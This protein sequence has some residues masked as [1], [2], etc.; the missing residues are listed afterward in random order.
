MGK[1]SYAKTEKEKRIE[2]FFLFSSLFYIISSVI[3]LKVYGCYDAIE[4]TFFFLI[5]PI[6]IIFVVF[7]RKYEF[8]FYYEGC[9]SYICRMFVIIVYS[10]S[11][12][13]LS[14][15]YVSFF[16]TVL[17]PQRTFYYSGRVVDK[18][19]ENR[20]RYRRPDQKDYIIVLN[21]EDRGEKKFSVSY[22]EFYK[23]K[24][25]Q[26]YSVK[27]REGGLGIV[28]RDED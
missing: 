13:V 6:F 8:L 22:S 21:I 12:S 9:K 1:I 24:K 18:I 7:S 28:C 20:A 5:L 26:F 27:M 2:K 15:G 16:N 4:T 3:L 19:I 17:P 10:I 14:G 23:I 25:E 11:F